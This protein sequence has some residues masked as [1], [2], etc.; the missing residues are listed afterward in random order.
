MRIHIN[1]SITYRVHML[2]ILYNSTRV[3][4]Y[5]TFPSPAIHGAQQPPFPGVV[6]QGL[7]ELFCRYGCG[8]R[9]R[10]RKR[11]GF[12]VLNSKFSKINIL[13][14]VRYGT[15]YHV[16]YGTGTLNT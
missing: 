13:A 4:D 5:R 2:F 16:Q 7:V 9:I 10:A 8:D 3:H 6:Y 11:C 12:H 14:P 15:V 1:I